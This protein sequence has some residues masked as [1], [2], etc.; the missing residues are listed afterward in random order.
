ME[1]R[2]KILLRQKNRAEAVNQSPDGRRYHQS[3]IPVSIPVQ[4]AP[5]PPPRSGDNNSSN[6]P[7]LQDHLS[8][9]TPQIIKRTETRSSTMTSSFHANCYH[10][11]GNNFDKSKPVLSSSFPPRYS[12]SSSYI[13]TTFVGPSNSAKS[14]TAQHNKSNTTLSPSSH[15]SE[16]S[17]VYTHVKPHPVQTDK[18]SS[19]PIP[20]PQSDPR[21][22][23]VKASS[24]PDLRFR[25]KI[26]CTASP[27]TV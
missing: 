12:S 27:T 20:V 6:N 15:T 13:Q 17:S 14:E 23:E 21:N 8:Q 2:E 25:R 18:S 1:I 3:A 11:S 7:F 24:S 5:K 19:L 26:D 16:T 22:P 4:N 10:Q 9:G